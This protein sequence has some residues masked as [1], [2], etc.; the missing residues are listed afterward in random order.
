MIGIMKNNQLTKSYCY[1]F[2]TYYRNAVIDKEKIAQFNTEKIEKMS[3]TRNQTE[4]KEYKDYY[5]KHQ[6]E[7]GK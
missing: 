3:N 6:S 1:A 2:T 7:Y 4:Y 5:L